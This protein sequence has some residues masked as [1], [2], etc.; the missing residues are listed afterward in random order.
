MCLE[1]VSEPSSPHESYTNETR[2]RAFLNPNLRSR[3]VFSAQGHH[4]DMKSKV[5]L[6]DNAGPRSAREAERVI[7]VHSG[8][9][10]VRERAICRH[11]DLEPART[12]HVET[13][14]VLPTLPAS[15]VEAHAKEAAAQLQNT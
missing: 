3:T 15:V 10:R 8:I 6:I 12:T 13:E 9:E 2:R 1:F 4:I 11:V 14:T 7:A 5:M